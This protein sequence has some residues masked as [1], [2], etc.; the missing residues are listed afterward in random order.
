MILG[1]VHNWLGSGNYPLTED[2]AKGLWNQVNYL[3]IEQACCTIIYSTNNEEKIWTLRRLSEN[4]IKKAQDVIR[5]ISEHTHAT[6][7]IRTM[8]KEI[9]KDAQ[10]TKPRN[11]QSN[12]KSESPFIHSN[13][14]YIKMEDGSMVKKDGDTYNVG[15]ANAVGPNSEGHHVL[16]TQYSNQNYNEL[17]L[18]TLYKE[19]E[20]LRI[21]LKKLSQSPE[22]DKAIG[23]IASAE[24]EIK[25]GDRSKALDY[26]K[27]AGT[28]AFDV[29]T[30]I[31]VGVA[32]VALKTALGL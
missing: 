26:L 13:N 23:A 10:K 25:R 6:D 20:I 29:A 2:L 8:A 28:W 27:Q 5:V 32:I 17:N 19:L 30:K 14:T 24:I 9:M 1:E 22:E 12:H 18:D 15:Q 16:M 7:E 3:T 4:K 11:Q 31:G 21:E